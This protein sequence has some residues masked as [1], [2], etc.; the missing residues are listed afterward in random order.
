MPGIDL[1]SSIGF[2]ARYEDLEGFRVQDQ[3]EQWEIGVN[4][5]PTDNVVLKFDYRD[6]EHDLAESSGRD[7]KALDIGVGFQF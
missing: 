2:Y 7:F 4:L 5:W 3:F 1:I 6:R